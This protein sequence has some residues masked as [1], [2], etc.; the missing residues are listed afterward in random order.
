M[1]LSYDLNLY[2]NTLITKEKCIE[3]LF[4]NLLGCECPL[5]FGTTSRTAA[6]DFDNMFTTSNPWM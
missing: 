2:Y 5:L 1:Y 6:L 4:F 3:R